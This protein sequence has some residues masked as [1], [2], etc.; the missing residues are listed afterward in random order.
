MFLLDFWICL[1]DHHKTYILF[2]NI[3]IIIF[4][5]LFTYVKLNTDAGSYYFI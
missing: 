5:F 4:I 2:L 3:M 1:N